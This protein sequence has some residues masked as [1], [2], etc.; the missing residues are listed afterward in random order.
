[1]KKTEVPDAAEAPGKTVTMT[2]TMTMK[3]L[4]SGQARKR[5]ANRATIGTGP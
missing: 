2:M 1:M 5:G 4:K 3:M